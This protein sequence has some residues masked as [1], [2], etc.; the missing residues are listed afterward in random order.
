MSRF[1]LI[2]A[3][4][5]VLDEAKD[6]K[7]V[8][9]VLLG[10]IYA[11]KKTDIKDIDKASPIIPPIAPEKLRKYISYSR[12]Y[13]HPV[14]SDEAASRIKEY[15]LNLRKL[16][17]QQNTYPVTAREIE[18]LIRLSEAS[19]KVRLS[20]D[21]ELRDAERAINL[22]HFVLSDI[23]IDKETGKID[24]D[25]INIGQPKSKVDKLRALLGIIN[26]LEQKYD[27]VDI[28]DIVHEAATVGIDE[29]YTRR[30]IDE[31]KRQ[32][33]L[34]EPKVGHVKTSRSKG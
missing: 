5:D 16:G 15:Y 12:K 11:A 23:F 28:D 26:T 1:D 4:K 17:A 9:H 27:T 20:P 6:R 10:H 8:D 18:G 21:V 3:I 19:A 2:F 32:G 7:L 14:L 29:D 34:Y 22:V 25:V 24:S 31:L 13:V 30:L 33:D